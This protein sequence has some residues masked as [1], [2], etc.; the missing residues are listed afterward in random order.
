MQEGFAKL[1]IEKPTK[2]SKELEVFY[3]PAMEFNRSVSISLLNALDRKGMQIADPLAGSGVRSV[4]FLLELKKGI[5]KNISINDLNPKSIKLINENLKLNKI[6]KTKNL[7]KSNKILASNKEANLFLLESCGFDYIDID[8][9][10]SPV[11]FLDSAIQRLARNGILAVTATDTGALSGS[12]E[13]ACKRRYWAK[14]LRNELMHE[15]GLRILIRRVQLTGTTYD[16][17]LTPILSYSKEHYMRIFFLCEKGKEKA[18]TILKLHKELEVEGN[19]YG[20][21]WTGKFNDTKIVEKTI[22]EY[23]KLGMDKEEKQRG[24]KFLKLIEDESKI[25]Q[26]GFYDIHMIA[27]KYKLNCPKKEDVIEELKKRKIKVAESHCLPTGL[28]VEIGKEE[29]VEIIKKLNGK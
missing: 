12:F 2:V 16:K 14:P 17:A 27:G 1:N 8:P 25:N 29:F 4:R 15:I 3:N 11:K 18:D 7:K 24:I 22:K 13:S 5:I 10:G 9:F 19:K 23:E 6:K 28:K 20:P 21:V 26:V